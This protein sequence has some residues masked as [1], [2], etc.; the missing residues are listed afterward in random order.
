M[1][2]SACKLLSRACP[3]A[4]S[5]AGLVA[6]PHHAPLCVQAQ[7]TAPNS[8]IYSRALAPYGYR[9]DLASRRAASEPLLD[10]FLHSHASNATHEEFLFT[11]LPP[12]LATGTWTLSLTHEDEPSGTFQVDGSPLAVHISH[13]DIYSLNVTAIQTIEAGASLDVWLYVWVRFP[14]EHNRCMICMIG[15]MA[16]SRCSA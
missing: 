16:P 5:P 15:K 11:F 2:G 8:R 12:L 1:H 6:A 10:F 14:Q 7:M 3:L 4:I 13:G 9:G